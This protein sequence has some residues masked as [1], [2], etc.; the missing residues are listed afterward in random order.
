MTTNVSEDGTKAELHIARSNASNEEL[1]ARLWIDPA[2]EKRLVRKL[3]LWIAPV[4]MIVFL[5][6]YLDRSNIGNAASA[7]MTDDLGMTSKELGNAITLFYVTYVAFEVPCSLVLKKF[8]PSRLISLLIF[9]WSIVLIG[10]GFMRTVGQLYAS[11]LL[12]GVFES[13]IFP[14]LVIYLSTYYQ[15]EEQ[16]LRISYLFV[17]AALSGSFGGLFAYALIK[18]DGIQGIAG[19]RWLF[20]IEGTA[21]VLVAVFVFFVMA[22]DFENAKFLSEEDKQLMRIRAERNARYNGKPDFDWAEVRKAATDPK[23]Y[24][25]CWSQFW[26]DICSF[27]MSSFLP[28]IIR[29]FGYDT[30]TTQL[31]TIP[32]FFWASCTYI[33]VSWMSDRWRRRAFFMIPAGIITTAGYAINV[34]VPMSSTAALY[35]SLFIIA[36]GIYIMVGLNCAWLTNTHAGYYK[37]SMAVGMNQ[38]IGNT[39]GLVVG[40]IFAHRTQDGKYLLGLSFSLGSALLACL[41][42]ATLYW[43]LK[44]EN[45]KRMSMSD[46]EKEHEIQHGKG[47]DF[48]PDYRYSL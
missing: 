24:V 25:S 7:G 13:G 34:G 9:C 23:L 30:I 4:M 12:L 15:R 28:L 36:P 33:I 47:G 37:R 22:D 42:H 27:G 18:M 39:A 44:R 46:E 17:S 26:A 29:S 5:T 10:T 19:W 11:R 45:E 35:F 38:S 3:D 8:R 48:H 2:R 20:I 31:L 6:A 40:Q 1:A 41:G 21:S 43:H 14:C 32:V 16:A